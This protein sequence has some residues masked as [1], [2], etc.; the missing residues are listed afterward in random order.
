[1]RGPKQT[2]IM[3]KGKCEKRSSEIQAYRRLL[4]R[5]LGDRPDILNDSHKWARIAEG[6]TRTYIGKTPEQI[7]ST[8]PHL[9][10]RVRRVNIEWLINTDIDEPTMR[11]V[12]F[13]FASAAGYSLGRDWDWDPGD[14]KISALILDL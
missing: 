4:Q 12:L 7:H 1:M 13:R 9:I 5:F 3:F 14:G 10:D 11:K 8:T 6:A 2:Q